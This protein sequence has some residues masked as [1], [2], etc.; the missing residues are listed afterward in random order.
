MSKCGCNAA[1]P[2]FKDMSEATKDFIENTS[3][4]ILAIKSFQQ[5]WKK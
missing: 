1:A 5:V 2:E 3:R 4:M